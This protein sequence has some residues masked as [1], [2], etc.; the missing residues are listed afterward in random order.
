MEDDERFNSMVEA[1]LAAHE[2]VIEV[3]TPAMLAMTRALLWQVGQELAQ[4]EE[5]R[6]E[7]LRLDDAK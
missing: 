6:K 5:R 4:R 3:G 2:A 7:M 1:C